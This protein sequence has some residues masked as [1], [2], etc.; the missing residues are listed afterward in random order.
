MNLTGTSQIMFIQHVID[1][2]YM[3]NVI[4]YMLDKPSRNN[5]PIGMGGGVSIRINGHHT[6][7]VND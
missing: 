2:T 4:D 1:Y 6:D 5:I 7:N 3:P